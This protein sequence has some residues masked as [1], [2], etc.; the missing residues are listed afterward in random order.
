MKTGAAHERLRVLRLP[1]NICAVR[2]RVARVR[3]RA[4]L[5]YHRFISRA[6][7]H[8]HKSKIDGYSGITRCGAGR[9][10]KMT[11]L[12]IIKVTV[13][14]NDRREIGSSG[15][16]PLFLFLFS[17]YP[18]LSLFLSLSLFGFSFFLLQGGKEVARPTRLAF[19]MDIKG[20]T[21]E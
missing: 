10:R 2:D 16:I 12:E 11:L 13:R 8:H 18:I 3:A 9:A 20:P 19:T 5:L 15:Q 4:F 21:P 1:A 17:F 6:R 7:F 14:C